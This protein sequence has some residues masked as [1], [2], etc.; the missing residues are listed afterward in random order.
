MCHPD[1]VESNLSIMHLLSTK[2]KLP[3]FSWIEEKDID[4]EC[5]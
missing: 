2:Q 3:F 1:V 4:L 5:S